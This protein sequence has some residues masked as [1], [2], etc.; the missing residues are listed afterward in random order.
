MKV[1]RLSDILEEFLSVDKYV[2]VMFMW[3]FFFLFVVKVYI[4]VILIVG[5]IFKYFVEGL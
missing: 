1:L 5:K 2:F 3:N 4:D